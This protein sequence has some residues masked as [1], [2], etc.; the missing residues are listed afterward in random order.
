M[1]EVHLFGPMALTQRLLPELR[2]NKGRIVNLSSITALV[3]LPTG[4]A[5]GASKL[6]VEGV[7]DGLRRELADFGVSVSIVIPAY[8]NTAIFGKVTESINKDVE[9]SPAIMDVYGYFFRPEKRRKDRA[10]VDK[11]SPPSVTTDAI[12]HALT[13][14]CPKTRYIVA[15]VN[16]IPA[17][18]LGWLVWVCPDGL[19]DFIMKKF[20]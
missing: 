10:Q 3:V 19:A 17:F 2:K 6:A 12:T 11:A 14:P 16:G 4:S 8:V 7:S 1:F 15:N 18:L 20:S 5:Y 9:L 13:S